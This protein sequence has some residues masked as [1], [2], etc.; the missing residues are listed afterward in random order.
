M[1]ETEKDWI[2]LYIID[3]ENTYFFPIGNTHI[4]TI[5]YWNAVFEEGD[6]NR[7]RKG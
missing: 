3:K 4:L 6:Q 1:F 7:G 2:T 5:G